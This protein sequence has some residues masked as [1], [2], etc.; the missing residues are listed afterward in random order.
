MMRRAVVRALTILAVTVLAIAGTLSCSGDS[1]GPDA[2][3]PVGTA[4]QTP[5]NNAAPAQSQGG[6]PQALVGADASTGTLP[7]SATVS[8]SQLTG[9]GDL[10]WQD[11]S[12]DLLEERVAASLIAIENSAPAAAGVLL[13]LPWVADE[14]MLEERLAL[15]RMEEIAREDPALA[16]KVVALPW[17]ADDVDG[18]ELLA[19]E[20]ITDITKQDVGLARAVV[21]AP[22]TAQEVTSELRLTLAVIADISGNDPA[23]A[24]RIAGS[25]QAADG[26]SGADLVQLTNSENYYF[27]RIR[28]EAPDLARELS[29]MP[30]V[31]RNVT[32]A[33]IESQPAVGLLAA[34]LATDLTSHELWALYVFRVLAGVDESLALRVATFSWLSDGMSRDEEDILIALAEIAEEDLALANRL[35]DLPW[36]SDEIVYFKARAFTIMG[37]LAKHDTRNLDRLISQP[38]FQ[39]GLSLEEAAVIVVSGAGCGNV[40]QFWE[41]V[42]E[43]PQVRS[44]VL[45]LPSGDVTLLAVKRGSQGPIDDSVFEGMRTSITVMS[46]FMGQ[47]WPRDQAITLIEPDFV[48]YTDPEGL[49]TGEFIIVRDERATDVVYHEM[50]HHYH[51]GPDWINEGGAEFLTHYTFQVEGQTALDTR[52]RSVQASAARC[53]PNVQA[54][55]EASAGWS[56]YFYL[57]NRNC[58][59]VMGEYFLLGMYFGLGPEVVSAALWDL[60]EILTVTEADIYQAFFA[61]TPPEQQDQFRSLYAVLH[62]GTVPE[63]EV[64]PVSACDPAR[65][66]EALVALYNATDGPNWKLVGG[67]L[68][69]DP[70]G[71]WRG[72]TPDGDGCVAHLLLPDNGLAGTLPPEMGN[73]SSLEWLDLSHN[74]LTGEIPAVL[75]QLNHLQRFVLSGNQFSGPIPAELG[76][77]QD[78]ELLALANNQLSGPIPPELGNLTSL[79]SLELSLNRLT[80]PIPPELGNLGSLEGLGAESNELAGPLPPALGNLANLEWLRLGFN[81]ITGEIPSELGNLSSVHTIGLNYNQLTGPIPPSLGGL[82]E[83]KDLQL[84]VNQLTGPIPREIGN[85]SE[86]HNLQL[87][88]NQLSGE[89][90]PELGN[91]SSL[92]RLNLSSNPLTGPIP[93]ELGELNSLQYLD[94]SYSGLTGPIPEELGFLSPSAQIILVDTE[95]AG[96]LP[97]TLQSR[98]TVAFRASQIPGPDYATSY[99]Q[100]LEAH[101]AFLGGQ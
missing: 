18:Q 71:E 53:H 37:S 9:P 79:L 41:L 14:V 4:G 11:G 91:L 72:I 5:S 36:L 76:G 52:H 27:D 93:T 6:T 82:P 62:G 88:V 26:I 35:A 54:L 56:R 3:S 46:G 75:G 44:E 34:P 2:S 43:N 80:G 63:T 20:S 89:I 49:Y 21:E 16:Q 23:L 47:S 65:D 25:A 98:D 73:L 83:L 81:L 50:A 74:R 31:A 42:G 94:L 7:G 67:W 59:Y 58:H 68:S 97:A 96:P 60:H 61:N 32:G 13:A 17:L 29:G 101:R 66:R 19:L 90:P 24:R 22:W 38:W 28:E 85:R 77:L 12:L 78:L 40:G 87:Q 92:V 86:L 64:R 30:W 8:S 100:G 57:E 70:I 10:A 39:D 1:D 69:D 84:Q 51:F 99:S 48:S 55:L 33:R 15:P 45:S 95:L